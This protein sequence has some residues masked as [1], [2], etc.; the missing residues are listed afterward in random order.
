V[1]AIGGSL[2][3]AT[4]RRPPERTLAPNCRRV[5]QSRCVAVTDD[6][7]LKRAPLLKWVGGKQSLIQE[8]LKRIP[9]EARSGRYVEPFLGAGSLF[10]H[11]RPAR[12][13]VADANAHL[14]EFYERVRAN[15]GAVSAAVSKLQRVHGELRYYEVRRAF[16]DCSTWSA[17][18][19][20]RF[21]YLNRTCFNGIFRVNLAGEFNVPS[22]RRKLPYFPC[23]AHIRAAGRLLASADLRASDYR[24]TLDDVA[25]GDFVYIDPP[26]PPLTKTA[27]FTHYTMDRFGPEDQELLADKVRAV[28]ARGARFLLSNADTKEVRNLYRGFQFEVL[29]VRRYVTCKHEKQNVNEL[30]V[31]N[32]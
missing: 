31:R 18:Q 9:S 12:S 3:R 25:R 16:N 14:I 5:P 23:A 17:M 19:A 15:P 4:L 27:Y 26:Y 10:F 30:L 1:P 32:Y 2:S 7:S 6:A 8:L 22:G 29:P 24:E 11:L 28:S 21:L 13:I 20:A